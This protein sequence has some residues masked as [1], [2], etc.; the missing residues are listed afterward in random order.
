MGNLALKLLAIFVFVAVVAAAPIYAADLEVSCSQNACLANH[1]RPLFEIKD[2]TSSLNVAKE[3]SIKNETDVART[4]FVAVPALLDS[5]PS[6]AKI[7]TITIKKSGSDRFVYGPTMLSRLQELGNV[8]LTAIPA[9]HSETYQINVSSSDLGND[10]QNKTLNLDL[11]FGFLD[12]PSNPVIPEQAETLPVIPDKPLAQI[13][14]PE[15]VA[16]LPTNSRQIVTTLQ[17]RGQVQGVATENKTT[18]GRYWWLLLL[19]PVTGT[20]VL[21]WRRVSRSPLPGEK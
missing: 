4:T 1:H 10:Y 2:V 20:I 18:D 19:I 11:T 12:A 13:R 17:Q 3:V 6:L 14:N 9:N 16:S 15:T 8:E 5:Q 21:L 7:L